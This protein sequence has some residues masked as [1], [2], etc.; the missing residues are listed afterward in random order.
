MT[1]VARGGCG[2]GA[3]R[4][5]S[6]GSNT[7][8]CLETNTGSTTRFGIAV[9]ATTSATASTIDAFASIPV[10]AASTPMSDATARTWAATVP[11]EIASKPWT[12]SVFWTVTAVMAV[13]PKTPKAEKVLRIGLDPRSPAGVAAGDRERPRPRVRT[14]HAKW[15]H[16]AGSRGRVAP[17]SSV[18]SSPSRVIVPIAVSGVANTSA[19]S[20]AASATAASEGIVASSS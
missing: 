4:T 20:R 3:R 14:G 18:A 17:R 9:S 6:S 15:S 2:F 8:P 1:I 13:I 16:P 5:A 19:S 12:P 10:F 11:G 7:C